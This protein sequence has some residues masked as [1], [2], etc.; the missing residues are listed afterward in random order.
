MAR[1]LLWG[2]VGI[3]MSWFGFARELS[4][5][6]FAD[7]ENIPFAVLLVTWLSSDLHPVPGV[8]WVCPGKELIFIWFGGVDMNQQ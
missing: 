2:G 7:V 5:L 1:R 6:R 8:H 4:W 3:W